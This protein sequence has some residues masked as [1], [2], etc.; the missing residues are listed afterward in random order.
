MCGREG[1]EKTRNGFVIFEL[2]FEW[3][4]R[5]EGR[6]TLPFLTLPVSVLLNLCVFKYILFH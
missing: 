3:T 1:K 6:T 4:R 2:I 5:E